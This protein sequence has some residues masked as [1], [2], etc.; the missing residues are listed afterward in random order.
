M[1]AEQLANEI[2]GSARE[3]DAQ[4]RETGE[5]SSICIET[6]LNRRNLRAELRAWTAHASPDTL[7]VLLSISAASE[8]LSVWQSAYPELLG[9][10]RAIAAA[11]EWVAAPT[12]DA[13]R[14]ASSA[15]ERASAEAQRVWHEN[16]EAGWAGR[17]A[18]WAGMAP[19]YPWA[20]VAA[21]VGAVRAANQDVVARA[22]R[23]ALSGISRRG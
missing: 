5:P 23:N 11:E 7:I 10:M 13:A 19:S 14:A 21:L 4:R 2:L 17:A 6:L 3:L 18:S 16:R 15:A 9:P 22:L 1:D 8:V 12:L 20:A